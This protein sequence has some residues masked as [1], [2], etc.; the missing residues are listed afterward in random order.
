MEE[1]DPIVAEIPVHLAEELRK[2]MYVLRL[3]SLLVL[4]VSKLT[5]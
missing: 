5:H 1:D 3:L 4:P 2:N